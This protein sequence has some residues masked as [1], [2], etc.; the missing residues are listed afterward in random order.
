MNILDQITAPSD[1]RAMSAADLARLAADIRGRILETVGRNGGH[2]AANLGVVELTLA[3]LRAFDPPSDKILWDVGHQTYAWKLLTGRRAAFDTLRLPGGISGFQKRSESP[4]DAFGAGHAGTALSAALGMAV[5]RDRR[6]GREYVVAVVGDA[7]IGNGISLE[8]LNNIEGTTGR[9]IVILNDNEMSIGGAVGSLSRHLGKLLA[10]PKYNRWKAAV[11][12]LGQQL[13]MTPLRNAYHRTEQA[14]KSLF[15]ENALFEEF[16]LRYMGPIDGHDRQA[17]ENALAIAKAYDR[18]ILL[19]VATRKGRGYAAAEQAP[20]RWH[21]VGQFDVATARIAESPPG[22]SQAFGAC[23]VRLAD[24]DPRVTAVTA[25]MCTGTGLT[26]FQAR[27]PGRFFDVGICE[28][29]AVVF[30]AG[31][32]AEGLRPVVAIYST[33]IQRAIDCIMHDVCLQQLPVLFCLDRAGVV[34]N[35]GPT[36]HGVFDL[37]MLRALP[38]LTIMQPC[39]EPEL[40][41]MLATALAHEGPSVIRYPRDAGPGMPVPEMP[42]T[43]PIGEAAVVEPLESRPVAGRPVWFWALGDMLPVAVAAARIVRDAGCAAGV[44]NARFIKP[45]DLGLLAGQAA[46]GA[47]FVTLENGARNGGFGS[48][49]QDALADQARANPVLRC[50]WPDRFVEQGTTSGLMAQHGLT[51]PQV[52]AR[53][54]DVL[55]GRSPVQA[56][57]L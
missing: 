30:A 50:G 25:A 18:P 37:A 41:R 39:D 4:Y 28:E 16:G 14:V 10:S 52:A 15:L 11:E 24:R 53:V 20:E 19:H 38:G 54:L 48:A 51:A 29:H 31:L 6:G 3:L 55:Q 45:L 33:F 46:S 27:H 9:L 5:A 40:A 56:G 22:Y 34:G 42:E 35:D 12:H 32:A 26:P 8:A 36:H 2:L 47:M 44:V 17:V 7:A 43:L 13:R 57:S 21:G 49:L 23:L 1:L